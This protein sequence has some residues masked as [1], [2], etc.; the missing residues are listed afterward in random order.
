MTTTAERGLNGAPGSCM[1]THVSD[2][3]TAGTLPPDGTVCP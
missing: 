1:Q 3:L 2:Y